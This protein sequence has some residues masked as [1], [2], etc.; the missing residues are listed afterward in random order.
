M[1]I[2]ILGGGQLGMMLAHAGARLGHTCRFLD[3]DPEA[4][5]QR[6][7]EFICAPFDDPAAIDRFAHGLDV[8]TFEFENVPVATAEAVAARVPVAPSVA[9]LRVTQDRLEEKRWFARSDFDTA[10][11]ARVESLEDLR[12]AISSI[13]LPAILKTRRGGYDGK[14]QARLRVVSD[15]EPAWNSI[16]GQPA[17]SESMI[18]FDR[19]LSLIG[20][21]ASDGTI[22]WAPLVENSHA[23]GILRLTRAPAPHIDPAIERAAHAHARA[24]MESLHHV[25]VFTVELFQVGGRLLANE[26]APRVHNSGHWTIEGAPTSQFEN[27][28]RAVTGAPVLPMDP[29]GPCAVLNLIGS[30]PDAARAI[31]EPG[32]TVHEYGKP[33]RAG[34][35]VGHITI[36]GRSLAETDALVARLTADLGLAQ[37]DAR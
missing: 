9:S 7:G 35:K 16:G 13:G 11:W 29:A 26:T 25:G 31:R 33:P 24:L 34:R 6:A 2:G 22:A 3:P 4:C 14:G 19:E 18:R 37:N 28:I 12:A 32:V 21:R 1:R 8:A 10:P 15:A 20:A 23:G 17:I 36:A 27:H 5:A 30:I